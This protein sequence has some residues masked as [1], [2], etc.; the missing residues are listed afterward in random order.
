MPQIAE[1]LLSHKW[2]ILF[3]AAVFL[4]IFFNRKK[5][6]IHFR[7][8]ALYK[9][10][11]GIKLMD[12][13]ASRHSE[14]VKLIGYIGIGIGYAGML[15]ITYFIIY[16]LYQL[17]FVPNAPAT[18]S[19]VI[20]GV[21]IPGTSFFI[22]FLQGIIAIFMV[23]VVHEFG[24]GLVARA[25]KVE[26]KSTGPFVIGPFF[27]A[28]VEPDEDSLKKKS[29]VA[30]YSIFAAGP[31]FNILLAIALVGLINLAM[32]PLMSALFEPNGVAFSSFAEN[33][34]AAASGLEAGVA[35]NSINGKQIRNADEL[36]TALKGIK[37]G[38]EVK[39]SNSQDTAK[40]RTMMAAAHPEDSTKAYLGVTG[41]TNRYEND[42]TAV[43]KAYEWVLGLAILT[44]ILSLGI[45]LT[46]LLPV[47]PID[48]GRI[49]LLSMNRI[50]GEE[51]GKTAWAKLSLVF[52]FFILLLMTPILKA[53]FEAVAKAVA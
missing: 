31:F 46:N 36:V 43:F 27:G 32:A 13:I 51:R 53:T 1:A 3:Y 34:P 12:R 8:A 15:A 33:S 52:L 42:Q 25:H 44:Y 16:G 38:D 10:K 9:T 24:H 19:P 23:V 14:L 41:I 20:P 39:I 29:D 26:I 48:G 4:F 30:Q 49:L 47:G 40:S 35:Y 11:W 50:F 2:I 37:P 22:P 7:I 5:F 17:F 6:D 45:G 18:I 21:R 28:F